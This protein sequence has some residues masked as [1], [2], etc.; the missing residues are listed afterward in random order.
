MAIPV[1]AE[2]MKTLEPFHGKI[3]HAVHGG[4]AEW[5][6]VQ[7]LRTDAGFSPIMYQR[8]KSNDVFDA[9]ARQA[10]PLFVAEPKVTVKLDAQTF[11]LLFNGVMV[12]FKKGGEDGLG[13]SAPTQAALAFIEVDGLLP[14]IPPETAKIEII[15]RPN[16]IWTQLDGVYVVARDGD[17]LLWEYEIEDAGESSGVVP[18]A[19]PPSDSPEPDGADL[20]KPKLKPIAKPKKV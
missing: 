19:T 8:T 4:W 3:L 14:G 20:V 16:E 2:V 10:I 7:A 18:L 9:V 17:R 13:C 11:K 1:K 5:R 12:R 15:W 6:T